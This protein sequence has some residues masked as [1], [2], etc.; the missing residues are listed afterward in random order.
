MPCAPEEEPLPRG[1]CRSQ[2]Q[3]SANDRKDHASSRAGSLAASLRRF[4]IDLLDVAGRV[5]RQ[6]L[7]AKPPRVH[8]E[9]S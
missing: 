3:N 7:F 6:S 2:R 8:E 4:A 9:D 5:G 1:G